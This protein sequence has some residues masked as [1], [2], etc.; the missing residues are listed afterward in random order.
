MSQYVRNSVLD[1]DQSAPLL[2]HEVSVLYWLSLHLSQPQG[3]PLGQ[4]NVYIPERAAGHGLTSPHRDTNISLHVS[5]SLVVF[6]QNS[7]SEAICGLGTHVF[8]ENGL[9]VSHG[10]PVT[11]LPSR[12][13][14]QSA[15]VLALYCPAQEL[16]AEDKEAEVGRA[17]RQIPCFEELS[18]GQ[19]APGQ[20]G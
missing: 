17:S 13:L 15:I 14:L 20:P 10:S 6:K 18:Y 2:V 1:S 19:S 3:L 9:D 5:G 16:F 8:V 7:P 12:Y 4:R 11:L